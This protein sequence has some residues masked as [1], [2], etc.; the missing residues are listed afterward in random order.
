MK[1]GVR[2]RSFVIVGAAAAG[3]YAGSRAG[4]ERYEQINRFVGAATA[5]TRAPVGEKTAALRNLALEWVR[6]GIDDR[7][8][9]FRSRNGEIGRERN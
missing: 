2:L 7:L 8:Q 3:Y 9:S 6:D 1:W 5:G 4:R